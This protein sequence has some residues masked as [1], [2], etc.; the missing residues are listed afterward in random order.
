MLIAGAFFLNAVLSFALGLVVAFFLG[1]AEFG[2]YGIAIAAGVMANAVLFE[3]VRLSAT[4]FYSQATREREPAIRATLDLLLMGSIGLVALGTAVALMGGAGLVPHWPA[5]ISMG[6]A[7]AVALTALAMGTFDY[8]SALLRARFLD[9]AYARLVIVKNLLVVAAATAVAAYTV[10]A[11]ATAA[12]SALGAILAV[13]LV[14]RHLVDPGTGPRLASRPLA[15]R[16]AAYGMPIVAGNALLLAIPL[17]NRS[18]AAGTHGLAEAGFLALAGDIGA[19]IVTALGSA[20]DVWLFQVAVRTQE[21]EGEAAG[22]ARIGRNA[23]LMLAVLAPAMAG[24][25]LILPPFEA[26]LVPASF[27]GAFSAYSLALLPGFLALGIAQ[28]ALNPA[29]QLERRTAPI[30]L[31][32]MAGVAVDLVCI[33]LLPA[34][35]GAIGYAWAQSAG[36]VVMAVVLLAMAGGGIGLVRFAGDAARIALA[37]AAMAGVVWWLRELLAP[38]PVTELAVL[39]IAGGIAYA[40]AGFMLDAGGVRGLILDW[41]RGRVTPA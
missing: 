27:H 34:R 15:G 3:W 2:R 18:F 23:A 20:L 13:G 16:F 31:A 33:W 1:P 11:T 35:M 12:I 36:L 28:Y 4:R 32:A 29:F 22:R 6:L 10:S 9:R 14:A 7:V 39:T 21:Q 5:G 19:R 38:G 26:A 17:L 25:G 37:V 41:R 8:A 24:Y 40:A 30:T